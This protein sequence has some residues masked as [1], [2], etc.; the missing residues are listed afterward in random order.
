MLA[1]GICEDKFLE[2]K[3]IFNNLLE[4]KQET[5]AAFS[6]IHNKK[7][8]ISIFG[9]SKNSKNEPWEQ[10]TIVNTFSV[11]KGIYETCVAK[12]INENLINIEKPVCYYWPN[13]KKNYK[14]NILVKHILSHQSGIYRFKQKVENKDLIDWEKIIFILENQNA[15]HSPGEFTYYHAKTH[16]FLIGNLIK[17]ITGLSVGEYLKKEI[18]NKNNLNFYFGINNWNMTSVADLSLKIF[19]PEK[20]S[21]HADNYNAFNNPSHKINYYNSLEWRK[22]EIPSMGGHGNSDAIASIYDFLANDYKLDNQNI[23]KQN[24]LKKY[25]LETNSQKDL[26]LNF[27]IRWTNLGFILRSGWMFGK[28]K[29]SFGHNGWG[30]SLGFADPINGLGISYVTKEINPTMGADQRAIV[31]IKKLYELLV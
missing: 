4:T 20:I 9:G 13:F 17:I 27:K 25:L 2:V 26:S 11:S 10:D 31:L 22:S 24:L 12:L 3:N 23:I 30:G 18:T 15:D 21:F 16:G 1:Q 29:E 19:G 6:V 8:I 7:K 5:G 28:H 14:S